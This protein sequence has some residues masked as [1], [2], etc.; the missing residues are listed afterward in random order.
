MA[1]AAVISLKDTIERLMLMDPSRYLIY[2][3]STPQ[4]I[5]FVS[6]EVRLL[7]RALQELDGSVTNSRTERFEC[8]GWRDQ[9]GGE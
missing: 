5:G 3:E 4:I 2:T 6:N 8:S 9:E 1:Y 7:Q